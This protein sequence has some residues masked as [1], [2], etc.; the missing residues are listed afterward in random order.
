M[1]PTYL[2]AKDDNL[3][4]IE[5]DEESFR[6]DLERDSVHSSMSERPPPGRSSMEMRSGLS[7]E[8]RYAQLQRQSQ[9]RSSVETHHTVW[10]YIPLKIF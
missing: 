4:N 1:T 9:R 6:E 8:E 10:Q 5:V 2:G 3:D 7:H